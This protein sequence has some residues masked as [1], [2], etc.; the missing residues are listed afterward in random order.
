MAAKMEIF[1]S[2]SCFKNE[3]EIGSLTLT[4]SLGYQHAFSTKTRQFLI[5]KPSLKIPYQVALQTFQLWRLRN[6][7]S[8]ILR[9]LFEV[10]NMANMD[11]LRFQ[12]KPA[13]ASLPDSSSDKM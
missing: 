2:A 3:S 6:N 5:T 4:S 10:I 12:F 13:K 9:F 11:I 8:F 1:L 7:F